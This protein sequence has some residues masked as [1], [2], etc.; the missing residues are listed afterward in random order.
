MDVPEY[1][2]TEALPRKQRHLLYVFAWNEGQ[3][4]IDQLRNTAGP[5]GREFDIMIG[6]DHCTD[7]STDLEQLAE[8][9]VRGVT[10][11][12]R[13]MG[14]SS[15]IKAGLDWF[16]TQDYQSVVMMNGNGR[17]DP[18]A[19]PRFIEKLEDGYDYVQGSRFRPGGVHENTPAYRFWAIRLV[20]APL[21]SLAAWRWMTDTTN[22]Y[23]AFSAAY[24]RDLGPLIFQ[25]AFQKYEIEQY[26]AWKAIRTGR[27]T[28]EIPVAR[29]YAPIVRGQSFSKIRPGTGWFQMIKPLAMLLFRRYP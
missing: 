17:D 22:G 3:K 16:L 25:S 11:L 12:P 18:N 13:N 20:H 24:L 19:I 8:F 10:R 26:L 7:G 29:R 27:K 6:D 2:Y 1:S 21:F 14:L 15:N 4:F 5:E 28:C 9:G 23:R